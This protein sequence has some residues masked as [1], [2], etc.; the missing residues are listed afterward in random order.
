MASRQKS[1][2]W[3]VGENLTMKVEIMLLSLAIIK[4]TPY[5]GV[6]KNQHV[7]HKRT[8]TKLMVIFIYS[9]Y[10]LQGID[11]SLNIMLLI[12]NHHIKETSAG[13]KKM[14]RFDQTLQIGNSE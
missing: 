8:K 9:L 4:P 10:Y 13:V 5:Y 11:W 3:V 12:I 7:F 14:K 6:E 2:L 1:L